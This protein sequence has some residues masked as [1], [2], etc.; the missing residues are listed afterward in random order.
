MLKLFVILFII[1]LYAHINI[2]EH[3]DLCFAS[4]FIPQS[5]KNLVEFAI[6]IQV[7]ENI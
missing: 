4:L 3:V 1:K 6:K 2:Y 5:K 7:D